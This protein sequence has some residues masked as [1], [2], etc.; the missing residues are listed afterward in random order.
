MIESPGFAFGI[1][2]FL[3]YW[4]IY[5]VLGLD[6]GVGHLFVWIRNALE[7]LFFVDVT[8]K[9]VFPL[10]VTITRKPVLLCE[11]IHVRVRHVAV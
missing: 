10:S 5:N 2:V 3:R 7:I 9:F 1:R 4:I 8:R 11:L 6:V